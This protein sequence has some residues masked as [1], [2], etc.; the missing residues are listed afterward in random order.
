MKKNSQASQIKASCFKHFWISLWALQN[1][2]W[3]RMQFRWPSRTLTNCESRIHTLSK[4]SKL[5][6]TYLSV[7]NSLDNLFSVAFINAYNLRDEISS[8]NTIPLK[9]FLHRMESNKSFWNNCCRTLKTQ[10]LSTKNRNQQMFWD[11]AFRN[12]KTLWSTQRHK[13]FIFWWEH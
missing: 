8:S 12:L 4:I 11:H 10:F 6:R 13:F 1:T 5:T 2:G 3:L 7:W 9:S